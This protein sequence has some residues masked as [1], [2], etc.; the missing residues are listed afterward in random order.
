MALRTWEDIFLQPTVS[1]YEFVGFHQPGG[2]R[3]IARAM[4]ATRNLAGTAYW[5]DEEW[6]DIDEWSVEQIPTGEMR[7]SFEN[8]DCIHRRWLLL[9]TYCEWV[10]CWHDAQVEAMCAEN[11]AHLATWGWPPSDWEDID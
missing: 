10:E 11:R 2:L 5:E 4:Q 6:V 8:L 1:P 3:C 7:V 9:V